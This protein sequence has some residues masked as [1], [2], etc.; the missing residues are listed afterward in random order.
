M[1]CIL[2][3]FIDEKAYTFEWFG[4]NVYDCSFIF[5]SIRWTQTAVNEICR[6]NDDQLLSKHLM[7][8]GNQNLYIIIK[9]DLSFILIIKFWERKKYQ[10]IRV[11]LRGNL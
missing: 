6:F 11:V 7:A 2:V 5:S 3:Y 10:T 8:D 9:S 1:E 4:G